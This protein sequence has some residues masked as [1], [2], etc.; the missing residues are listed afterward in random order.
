[1]DKLDGVGPVDNRPSSEE[2][3]HLVQY[4]YLYLYDRGHVTFDMWHMEGG[5][6]SLKILGP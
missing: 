6:H 3:L 5:E 4:I 1:M 2:L